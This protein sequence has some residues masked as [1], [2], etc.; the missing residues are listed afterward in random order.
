MGYSSGEVHDIMLMNFSLALLQRSIR[1]VSL[2]AMYI[3]DFKC[4]EKFTEFNQMYPIEVG[5]TIESILWLSSP[6]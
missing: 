2:Q 4:R 3:L 6:N 5:N 1:N